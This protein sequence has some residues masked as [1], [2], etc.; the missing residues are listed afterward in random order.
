[1][2]ELAREVRQVKQRFQRDDADQRPYLVRSL[3][4]ELRNRD[5][6]ERRDRLDEAFVVAAQGL[7][8]EHQRA[9]RGLSKALMRHWARMRA[10]PPSKRAAWRH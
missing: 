10:S 9:L 6:P 2:A 1:M 5:K 7:T 3:K 8:N 4:V